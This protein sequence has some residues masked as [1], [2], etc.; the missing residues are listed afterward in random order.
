MMKS[1]KTKRMKE[2]DQNARQ[3]EGN[4]GKGDDT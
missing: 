1:E 3:E 2:E 4:Q